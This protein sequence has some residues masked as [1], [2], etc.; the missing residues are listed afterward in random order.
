MSLALLLMA[1]TG[2][3]ADEANIGSIA[4]NSTLEAY[5]IK[6]ANNLNDLAVYVNG[7]GT[8]STGGDETTAHDCTGLTFRLT[9]DITYSHKSLADGESNFTAIGNN[10]HSFNGHFNGDGHSISGIRISQGGSDYQGLF[11]G[12]GRGA[13]VERFTLD[14]ADITGKA[15][16]GG[17]VGFN[18]G[19]LTQ[20]VVTGTVTIRATQSYANF[21]GGIVGQNHG[22]TA[23]DRA[24][25]SLCTSS[26][27]LTIDGDAANCSA[28]GGLAGLNVGLM[29]DNL[30][31]GATIPAA[32]S[33]YGALTGSTSTPGL[34][35]RNYY[36]RCTVGSEA[37]ASNLPAVAYID[38]NRQQQTAYPIPLR[39][40]E[41][42]RMKAGWYVVNRDIS[43]DQGISFYG[44]THL[45]LSDGATMTVTSNSYYCVTAM[46]YGSGD[47][48]IYGQDEGT[49]ALNATSSGSGG[50]NAYAF[51]LNGGNLN[52]DVKTDALFTT[53]DITINGGSIR[54]NG[55]KS[56]YYG[57]HSSIGNIT[58]GAATITASGYCAT[59][60]SFGDDNGIIGVKQGVILTDGEGHYFEGQLSFKDS[61]NALDGLTLRPLEWAGS[62]TEDEPYLISNTAEFDL[63]LSRRVGEG[64]TYS[65]KFF[66][67][68]ADINVET[69]VGT[70][71]HPFSAHFDGNHKTL[72]VNYN[73]SEDY[74]APF[75]YVN[76][77]TIMNL[78]VAGSVTTSAKFAAGIIGQAKGENTISGS[79]VCATITSTVDGDGTH[80]GF[81]ANM[82]GGNTTISDSWFS[83]SLLGAMTNN[84]GGFVG[85][86]ENG[87][88]EE[89][90]LRNCLFSPASV[91]VGT[92]GS[93]TLARYSSNYYF[94]NNLNYYLTTLGDEQ[95]YRAYISDPSLTDYA[96]K[97]LADGN[98]YYVYAPV[99][100]H[101]DGNRDSEWGADY[102][103]VTEFT[104]SDAA[105]MAQ[106]TYLVNGGKDFSG[107]TITLAAD[108]DMGAYY[109][110]AICADYDWRKRV[111]FR[112][113]FDGA[114]HTLSNLRCIPEP[115]NDDQTSGLFGG[116]ENAT[117][118]NLT[119]TNL[120][121]ANGNKCD[122]GGIV[123]YAGKTTIE[124]CHVVSG[125]ITNTTGNSGYAGP[126]VGNSDHA[127]IKGCTVGADV[128]VSGWEKVG[129][130]VGHGLPASIHGCVSAATVVNSGQYSGGIVGDALTGDGA[131]N[132]FDDYT[133]VKDC[134]YL[135]H[136]VSGSSHVG[137]ITGY[138]QWA[139]H[140]T[141]TRNCYFSDAKFADKD[142]YAQFGGA[143]PMLHVYDTKPDHIGQQTEV[144]ASGITAYEGGLLYEGKYYTG[145][146]LS[147]D[148][149]NSAAIAAGQG[150][151]NATVTIDGR[152]FF[153]DYSW[154]T[155]C[156]PFNMTE[157]EVYNQ[158]YPYDY[159]LME[160]D[161]DGDHDGKKT[162]FDPD[163]GTLYLYFKSTSSIEAGK[164]YLVRW[165]KDYYGKDINVY[166][167]SF[168]GVTITSITPATV[169]A[170]NSGLRPVQFIG[171]YGS[172][173]LA[174]NDM[175]NLYLGA[176]N[177]LYYPNADG[178]SIG[179]FRAYF[180]IET[181]KLMAPNRIVMNILDEQSGDNGTNAMES[182]STP[183]SNGAETWY[184]LD[185]RR[186]NGKPTARG[187]YVRS[188]SGR[189]QGK[190]GGRK[191][192]ISDK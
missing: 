67:L 166:F 36:T 55:G 151:E 65:G 150:E 174:Q 16:T 131:E 6:N 38:E 85:W 175:S 72:T 19:T 156:L 118:K 180:H 23:S 163:D 138:Q 44:D 86:T 39:G 125:T 188:T 123:V 135:G 159:K 155:L 46:N 88:G 165:E 185:G 28:Y 27:T 7:T 77:A 73:T 113:T 5:E 140:H 80:G 42:Y 134:L 169:T 95:G 57:L 149:D 146:L 56:G 12:T 177:K 147:D 92:E 102:E 128:T 90:T 176:D 1:V 164:P 78:T 93:K 24:T 25:L 13:V 167:P 51:T 11:G 47:L 108:I 106:F 34:T 26:A 99:F 4:Y 79:H 45:I 22:N 127:K 117:I 105:D 89:L 129:G 186:L 173:P 69:M 54:A 190:N 20:V 179:A 40:C 132:Y 119:L 142:A 116:T 68:T 83:G 181:E 139:W 111:Y 84:C 61:Y 170:A 101:A 144:Y 154:N 71:D 189:L 49:G 124:N 192:L 74:T 114:G 122:V 136:S 112:G 107:K 75:R 60:N 153:K 171:T 97:T 103:N 115:G 191:V 41:T 143:T 59:G 50:I 178:F 17:I 53:N 70:S 3:W 18:R 62:G 33:T 2:A 66:Q 110:L 172:T 98:P 82:Q 9:N 64:N 63:L 183:S 182:I 104:I 148:G 30:A 161:T 168:Y 162:G 126:I 160:L 184:T 187:I 109:W 145:I 58:L 29:T 141:P 137:A 76:G 21:H 152:T 100:W 52:I 43:Y 94:N 14:D 130:I 15:Y 10:S 8:Y 37:N 96:Q 81:L 91:T 120:T 157:D 133:D 158:L 35:E 121:V 32:G 87:Y 31:D 48:T